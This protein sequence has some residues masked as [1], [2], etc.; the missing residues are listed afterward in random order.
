MKKAGRL[1]A[2]KVLIVGDNELSTDRGILR[3]MITREQ[4]EVDLSKVVETL[5]GIFLE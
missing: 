4:T 5:R 1:G 2:Q 3:D